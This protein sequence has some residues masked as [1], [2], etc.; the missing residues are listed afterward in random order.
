ML[1]TLS[2][3]VLNVLVGL[4]ASKARVNQRCIEARDHLVLYRQ[5]IGF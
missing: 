3:P 1:G 4:D 5:V 2:K